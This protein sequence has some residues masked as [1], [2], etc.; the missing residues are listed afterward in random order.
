MRRSVWGTLTAAVCILSLLTACSTGSPQSNAS[1][2]QNSSDITGYLKFVDDSP[3][4]IDP[5]CTSEYYTVALN[6]FDRLVEVCV[7]PETG[8]SD[9]APSLAESWE[10]SPDGLTYSFHLQEDVT[11]SD[12]SPLTASDVEFTLTRLLTHP[13]SVFH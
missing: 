2:T 6:V 12:G 7:D 5:Q 13:D 4:V 9:I 1:R 11:F 8:E 10:I 3:T